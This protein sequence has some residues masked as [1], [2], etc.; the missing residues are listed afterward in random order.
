MLTARGLTR[1]FGARHALRDVS[2]EV[3]AGETVALLGA[4]GAGKSTLLGI[5]AGI[6]RPTAGNATVAGLQ[7]PGDETRLGRV[8]GFVPQGESLYPEL[9]VREN[10]MFFGRAHGVARRDATERIGQL[11]RDLGLDDRL[12]DRAGALSG[13]LRQRATIAASLMHDPKVLLLDEPAAGLDLLARER[14]G[15]TLRALR[16]RERAILV[17]THHVADAVRDADRVIVLSRGAVA[18]SLPASEQA[19]VEATLRKLE[20]Q[21]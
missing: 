12:G 21:A 6:L 5:L 10:L 17:S 2:L 15:A 16:G 4:N 8:V 3:A 14:L 1:D 18:A 7:V 13:G 19:R 20:A 9:T 11:S